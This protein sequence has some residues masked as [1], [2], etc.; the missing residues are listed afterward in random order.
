MKRILHILLL[1]AVSMSVRAQD[2]QDVKHLEFDGVPINGRVADFVYK[3]VDKGY[4]QV[5]GET[6]LT[7][8]VLGQ[9]AQIVPASTP[10][11]TKMYLVLVNLQT[12]KSWENVKTC[13]DSMK[14]QLMVR[15]GDPILYKE[16]F[17]SVL[18][19]RDPIQALQ[20][21]NCTF[22]SHYKAEGGEIILSIS[23]DAVVQMY[24]VDTANA[25]SLY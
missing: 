4:K 18:A 2:P 17:D 22:I 12:K 20:Y 10:D 24:F 7:G 25:V 15:Y 9:K 8:K 3:L 5:K 21:G 6:Y 19:E 1:L 13:Y 14:M 16:E 23:K 11:G